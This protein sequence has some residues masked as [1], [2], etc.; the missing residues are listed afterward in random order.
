MTEEAIATYT[1][2]PA[3][4]KEVDASRQ[5]AESLLQVLD[6]WTITT[7]EDEG[8]ASA[9][10]TS[11]HARWKELDALRKKV[12][13][14]AFDAQKTINDHFRP[15]L[16]AWKKAKSE[17]QRV[18]AEAVERREAANQARVESA[19][20]GNAAAL[21]QIEEVAPPSG[22]SYREEVDIKIIDFD[23]IPREYLTVDWSHLKILVKEGKPAPP[24][25]EFRRKAKVV[26]TGRA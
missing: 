5:L 24:G 11:A 25:V 12:A 7:T 14:P 20:V 2:L 6:G 9:L 26:P 22:V 16:T 10:L 15:A 23:A 3:T 1:M 4:S 18:L 8:K 17:A 21:A 19:A 13:K